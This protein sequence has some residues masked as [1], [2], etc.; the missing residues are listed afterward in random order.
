[1]LACAM[2]AWPAD[3]VCAASAVAGELILRHRL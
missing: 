3:H 2:P 1:V